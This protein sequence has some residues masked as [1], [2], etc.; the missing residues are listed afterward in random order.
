MEIK[1]ILEKPCLE[2]DKFH[3]YA[4]QSSRNGYEIRETEEEYQAWGYTEEERTQQRQD[5]FE[6][7]FL[8]TSLGNYRL[9]P[10]GYANAQQSI[11][12]VNALVIYSQG[13]TE[14]IANKVIFYDTPDFTKPEECT[15]EWLVEHQHH[16]EPMTQQ[17]WAMF[18]IEFTQAYANKMYQEELKR[19]GE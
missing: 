4:E 6:S 15:E 1:A 12:T 17:Q 7:Q 11:D 8:A 14:Q 3:F 10:K 2:D 13:L 18:Y 19:K 9:N 5:D 16:P